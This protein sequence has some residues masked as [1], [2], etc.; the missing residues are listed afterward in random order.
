LY[1]NRRSVPWVRGINVGDAVIADAVTGAEVARGVVVKKRS[2]RMPPV[3]LR[4]SRGEL[5]VMRAWR[6]AGR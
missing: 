2:S 6:L 5:I 1:K 4:I 3:I